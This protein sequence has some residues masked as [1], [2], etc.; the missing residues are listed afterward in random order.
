MNAALNLSKGE[1]LTDAANSRCTCFVKLNGRLNF[2]PSFMPENFIYPNICESIHIF[3]WR[4]KLNDIS[5]V[6]SSNMK[7]IRRT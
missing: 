1:F 6:E 4:R 2:E 3:T 7:F 5:Q